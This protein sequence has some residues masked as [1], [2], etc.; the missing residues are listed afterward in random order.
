M[1]LGRGLGALITPT[2]THPSKSISSAGEINKIWQIPLSKIEAYP[3]QPR[4]HFDDDELTELSESIK[5]HGVLQP[6]IVTEK[7]D[8]GYELVAGERRLRATKLSGLA[9][10]PAIIKSFAPQEKLEVSLVENIQRSN[11]NPIEE[12]FAYKRLMDEFG[13]TQQAVAEKV[14]KSRPA[15]A[16]SIRLLDLPEPVKAAL[17]EQKINTGQARALLSLNSADEQLKVLSSMLGERITVRDLEREVAKR[18]SPD[19]SRRDSNLLFLETKLR[20]RLGTKVI[21]TQKGEQGTIVISY[22]SKEELGRLIEE[23]GE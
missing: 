12:A 10:I 7:T 9:T 21:I 11:L 20:S 4:K 1:S 23:I 6:I 15:V 17:V 19:K 2:T 14:G 18:R 5:K 16:N 22:H 13:L 3:N 8:G